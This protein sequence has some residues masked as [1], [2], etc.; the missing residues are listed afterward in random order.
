[1]KRTTSVVVRRKEAS[2]CTKLVAARKRGGFL[3]L[4]RERSSRPNDAS[5]RDETGRVSWGG[6]GRGKVPGTRSTSGGRRNGFLRL[7]REARGFYGGGK[8][9]RCNSLP[10]VE[11]E[12]EDYGTVH[13][14]QFLVVSDDIGR[15][16]LLL[17]CDDEG[18]VSFHGRLVVGTTCNLGQVAECI[19]MF[20]FLVDYQLQILFCFLVLQITLRSVTIHFPKKNKPL[21]SNNTQTHSIYHACAP[22]E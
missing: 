14:Q 18:K 12:K 10:T 6:E 21:P 16:F 22:T 9:L 20:R 7:R 8:G 15:G 13:L 3:D 19:H 11:R 5:E 1:M 4:V 17:L 2:R